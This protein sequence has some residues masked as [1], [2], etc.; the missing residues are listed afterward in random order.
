MKMVKESVQKLKTLTF[1]FLKY[2]MIV[3]F[4][5]REICAHAH[6]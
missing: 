1:F 5:C 2:K 6:L 4:S 3:T